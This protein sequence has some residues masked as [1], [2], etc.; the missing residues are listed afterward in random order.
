MSPAEAQ[1]KADESRL[2][3]KLRADGSFSVFGDFLSERD[4]RALIHYAQAYLARLS[5]N[6]EKNSSCSLAADAAFPAGRI[7]Q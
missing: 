3:F 5:Q 6:L 1:S 4:T 7:D 2:G